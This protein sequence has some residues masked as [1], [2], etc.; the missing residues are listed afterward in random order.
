MGLYCDEFSTETPIAVRE[1]FKGNRVTP[2]LRLF[3]SNESSGIHL[4]AFVS[5]YTGEKDLL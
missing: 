3:I 4:I 1:T 2:S 5:E